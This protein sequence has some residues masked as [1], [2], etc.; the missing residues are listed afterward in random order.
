MVFFSETGNEE[1]LGYWF[2]N[3]F[4]ISFNGMQIRIWTCINNILSIYINIICGKGYFGMKCTFFSQ[5]I[6]VYA[7]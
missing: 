3:V 1:E 7:S 2:P 5:H 4:N 6:S